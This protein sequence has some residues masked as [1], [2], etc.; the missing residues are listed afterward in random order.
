MRGLGARLALGRWMGCL[1]VPGYLGV[2]S[3]TSCAERRVSSTKARAESA[4]G[5][6]TKYSVKRVDSAAHRWGL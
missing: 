6:V 2:L 3:A 4:S 1:G 5:L